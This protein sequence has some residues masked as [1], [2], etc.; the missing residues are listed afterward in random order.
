MAK[1]YSSAIEGFSGRL[2]QLV[3]Y[4][5]NGK[6]CL[7]VRPA[8]VRNPRT[9]AQQATRARFGGSVQLAAR[10]RWAVMEGLRTVARQ[11]GMTAYNA[12]CSLNQHA[13]SMVDGSFAVDYS[14]LR[15][16]T[17]PVAPVAVSEAV[18]DD[19]N[20]L[21]VSFEKNPMHMRADGVDM[22]HLYVYCPEIGAGYL[23]AAVYRRQGRVAVALDD[24][25]E[26][27]EVHLYAFVSDAA[28]RCSETAYG[29]TVSIVPGDMATTPWGE[30]DDNEEVVADGQ[31]YDGFPATLPVGDTACGREGPERHP[32]IRKEQR[33]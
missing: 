10:M 1:L 11:A 14:V 8:A 20:V 21:N 2:G 4:Q 25:Y 18:V 26:G 24:M 19:N 15:L 9:A 12:F 6:W 28:G 16:S 7:R 23:A 5:W 33:L 30:N 17:G 29:G 31:I 32:G 3:G 27:R 13:F 22:V